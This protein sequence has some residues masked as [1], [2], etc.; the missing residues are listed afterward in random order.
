MATMTEAIIREP[1][2]TRGA[3]LGS[4]LR[5]SDAWLIPLEKEH[6]RELGEVV[7]QVRKRGLRLVD[8]D[9]ETF[10]LES[11]A[12]VL[13]N[14]ES[15]IED[16]LGFSVVRGLDLQGL[17]PEEAGAAYFAVGA[18]LGRPISQ[19]AQGHLIG[20]IQ[21][22]GRDIMKDPGV[23]GYQTRISL[24]FHTDTSTD[25]LCLLCYRQAKKGGM[26]SLVSLQTIYNRVLA[27][28]PGL[29]DVLY[30][31]FHYDC[32]EEQHPDGMPFYSR[33]AASVCQGKLSLRHNSGYAKSAERHES[34]PRLTE[35]Q[36]EVLNLIDKFSFDEEI[37]FDLRLEEGDMLFVNNYQIAHA[38][39]EF[40]DFA[41]PERKRHLLRL[42]LHLHR[43][44]P[45]A[46]DFD[47]RGGIVQTLD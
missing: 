34:C 45:L 8:M 42:W 40:E 32:R 22:T 18:V 30:E 39:T 47:N 9:R 25:L 26:S 7:D 28:A 11:L 46:A 16:G 20:D 12:P 41:E 29:I 21:D 24:P 6:Q 10:P 38:R 1:I 5:G 37:R 31:R 33:S 19:N 27:E 2:E 44:R 35:A 36:S 15:E 43:G 3:W 4:E 14:L 17:S 13:S 23:R